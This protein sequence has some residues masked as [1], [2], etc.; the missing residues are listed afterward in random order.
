MPVFPSKKIRNV[1]ATALLVSQERADT[2]TDECNGVISSEGGSNNA[3]TKIM[4]S[5]MIKMWGLLSSNPQKGGVVDNVPEDIV[6]KVPDCVI[7]QYT[8]G[9]DRV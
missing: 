3:F 1:L 9:V 7:E 4:A 8:V 6:D 2:E 5:H